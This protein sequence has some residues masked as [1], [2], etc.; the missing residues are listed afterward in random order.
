MVI[1]VGGLALGRD[2]GLNA[3]AFQGVENPPRLIG[4]VA[5]QG[6]GPDT[7]GALAVAHVGVVERVEEGRG[8]VRL[9]GRQLEV[10]S[11]ALAVAEEVDLRR[12]TPAGPAQRMVLRLAAVPFFPPPAA[13]RAARTTVP[14]RHH[15][16]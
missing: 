1:V 4:L 2:H 6:R 12:K 8:L 11:V 10:Q 3:A 13:Q 7:D 15:S 5:R 9:S 14:S 16:S